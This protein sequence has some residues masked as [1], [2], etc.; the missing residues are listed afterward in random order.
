MPYEVYKL[1]HFSS[2][3]LSLT[4]LA[5]ALVGN[6]KDRWIKVMSGMSGLLILVSGMGLLARVGVSHGEAFPLWV[7][8]KF[9]FWMILAIGGPITIRRLKSK[10]TPAFFMFIGVA[11][12]AAYFAVNKV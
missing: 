5:L 12:S 8:G 1:I 9:L 7:K 11:I 10:R 3:F 4:T 6:L 2:I